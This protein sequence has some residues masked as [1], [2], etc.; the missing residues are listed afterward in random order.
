M[1]EP[2]KLHVKIGDHE[3]E[4]VGPEDA[5]RAAFDEWKNLL[6]GMKAEE[7]T[8]AIAESEAAPVPISREEV[9]AGK[10]ESL[11]KD[12]GRM[13]S[14]RFLPRTEDRDADVLLLLLYGYKALKAQE[15]VPVTQLKPGLKQSGCT[16]ARVDKSGGS[17]YVTQGLLQKGG[18]GKGRC[19][20]GLSNAGEER[21]RQLFSQMAT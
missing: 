8:P 21:A 20:P 18:A 9:P 16:V 2:Y 4:A 19:I 14:V 17:R 11:F 6:S 1:A 13:I 5:V 12:D 7:R 15:D 3:F 10:L